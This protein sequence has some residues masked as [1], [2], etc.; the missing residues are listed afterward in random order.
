M[1]SIIHFAFSCLLFTTIDAYA[2]SSSDENIK[3]IKEDQ[4][5]VM[6]QFEPDYASAQLKR[7]EA[8]LEKIK[9]LDT[10]NISEKKRIRLIKALYKDLNSDKFQKTILVETQFEDDDDFEN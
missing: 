5:P 7:R 8:L 10:L 6:F 2:Q 1:K 4:Q 3:S 9:A